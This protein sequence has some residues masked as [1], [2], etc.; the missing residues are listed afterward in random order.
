[1][2]RV[3]TIIL[4]LLI[5]LPL[6]SPASAAM[7][8]YSGEMELVAVSGGGCLENDKPGSRFPLV[9]TLEQGNSSNARQFTGFFHGPDMQTGSF[10]GNDLGQLQVVY[11]D[12][13]DRPQGDALALSAT[14]GGLDGELRE[15]TQTDP[16]GCYFEKA[17][18][19]LKQVA[20]G[21]KA[22]S[23]Y[24]RQSNL[25]SAEAY[26]MSGQSLLQADKPDEAIREFT[27]S[28]NLRDR[29]NPNDP[30]RATPAVS[31]AIAHIMAGREVKALATMRGLLGDKSETGDAISKQRLAVTEKLCGAEQYLE[32]DAGRK[33][34]L[35]LMDIVTREFG[36]F[37][38][39][40]VPLAV[41]YNEIAKEYKD[42]DDPE[43]AIEFFQKAFKLNPGNPD[44]IAG[45]V[46]SFVDA[47]APAEGR[48][49][50]NEHAET[51]M[52]S[53]G[54]GPYDVLL[55]Y[56]Y[57]SEAQQDENNGDFSR[58]EE[59]FREALKSRPGERN[60]VV[61][62]TRV[63]EKEGKSAEARK[64]LEDGRKGCRDQ[65]CRQEYDTEVA[66]QDMI[67]R[68]VKRLETQSGM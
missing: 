60:L 55:S 62:L 33:A 9:L 58:A 45:A 28:L 46:M 50:L 19:R 37:N 63:L 12:K 38:G 44:G 35:R 17:A 54:K 21:S 59:Q 64:L 8:L 11:P 1:M 42:Q 22:E 52:K 27:K 3:S 23:E 2:N 7:T 6:A 36:S 39:V 43:S 57:A 18:L 68:M 4:F 15:K 51:F 47:E 49:Y 56:L 30:D 26:F 10:S 61:A 41:C 48:R 66:R 34:A 5:A 31:I 65:T 25:F 14:P 53:A 32:S 20:T 67:N 24:V 40:A 16:A 13:P 29:V